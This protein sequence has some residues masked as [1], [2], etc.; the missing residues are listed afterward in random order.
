[1]SQET[2]NPLVKKL[3][4]SVLKNTAKHCVKWN[5]FSTE[6]I[7]FLLGCEKYIKIQWGNAVYCNSWDHFWRFMAETSISAWFHQQFFHKGQEWIICNT[8]IIKLKWRIKS[9]KQNYLMFGYSN[10]L[11]PT[12]FPSKKNI[13]EIRLKLTTFHS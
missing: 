10:C 6:N 3:M 12:I 7:I 5:V 11:I 9:N 4:F 1:M 8:K 13:G 2:V